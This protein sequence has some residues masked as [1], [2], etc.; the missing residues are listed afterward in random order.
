M[1]LEVRKCPRKEDE[2]KKGE[3]IEVVFKEN[4]YIQSVMIKYFVFLDFFFLKKMPFIL[5][6]K[7]FKLQTS[8]LNSKLPDSYLI[9]KEQSAQREERKEVERISRGFGGG[10]GKTRWRSGEG[11][12]EQSRQ[13]TSP[14]SPALP[15]TA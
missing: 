12:K 15:L 9:P 11:G 3:K 2:N 1:G 13:S 6:A 8:N 10:R 14:A 7:L 5:P 4:D